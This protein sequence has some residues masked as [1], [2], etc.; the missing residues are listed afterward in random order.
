MANVLRFVIKEKR[1]KVNKKDSIAS[2]C[3]VIIFPGIRYY[4]SENA[5]ICDEKIT[6]RRKNTIK[7]PI[8]PKRKR[9][10]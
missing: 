4:R 8:E 7:T 9:G 2:G 1:S 5:E 6:K 3:E 10:T